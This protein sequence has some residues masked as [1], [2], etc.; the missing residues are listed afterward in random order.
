MQEASHTQNRLR[1]A[2]LPSVAAS[3]SQDWCGRRAFVRIDTD[4]LAVGAQIDASIG[5]NNSRDRERI[6][7]IVSS[8]IKRDLQAELGAE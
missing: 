1:R 6:V 2:N 5:L 4:E 3:R 7:D 8:A